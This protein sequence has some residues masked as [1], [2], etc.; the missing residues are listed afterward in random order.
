MAADRQIIHE[1]PLFS[2]DKPRRLWGAHQ[3]IALAWTTLNGQTRD[4][5]QAAF[6][7]L[8]G[9][10][11]RA[12]LSKTQRQQL[13]GFVKEYA[14][15]D[16]GG[17]RVHIHRIASHIN[18][19]CGRCAN[20]KA[21]ID[22]ADP[23]S[24]SVT[25]LRPVSAGEQ[26]LIKYK[27]PNAHCFVC[28]TRWR[29]WTRARSQNQPRDTHVNPPEQPQETPT[30]EQQQPPANQQQPPEYGDASQGQGENAS[31]DQGQDASQVQQQPRTRGQRF[32][33]RARRLGQRFGTDHTVG[34]PVGLGE[35]ANWGL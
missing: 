13:E 18:H 6:A 31:Q 17:R 15:A 4:E 26:I 22:S 11:T 35:V 7:G 16:M 5:L 1:T 33:Q 12:G 32:R 29:W 9:L 24:I 3:S 28:G 25:L 23:N 27:K 14:S 10:S 20:A 19:A 2:C 8:L 21:S 34:G 30:Q